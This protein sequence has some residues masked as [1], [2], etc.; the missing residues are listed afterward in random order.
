MEFFFYQS[1]PQQGKKS[2]AAYQR[3]HGNAKRCMHV[4]DALVDAGSNRNDRRADDARNQ[5]HHTRSDHQFSAL[6]AV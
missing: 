5:T 2:K 4:V 3:Q 1:N 6:N